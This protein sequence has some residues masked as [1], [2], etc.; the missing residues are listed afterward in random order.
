MVTFNFVDGTPVRDYMIIKAYK[1]ESD[2]SKLKESVKGVENAKT[3]GEVIDALKPA[4]DSLL[5]GAKEFMDDPNTG[6]TLK[7]DTPCTHMFVLPLPDNLIDTLAHSYSSDTFKA[8]SMIHGVG[9]G[10]I[11]G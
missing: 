4:A 11:L 7:K 1:V 6:L 3:I 10:G 8:T 9:E 2:F 5:E